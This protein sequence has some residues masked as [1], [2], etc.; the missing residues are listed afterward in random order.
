MGLTGLPQRQSELLPAPIAVDRLEDSQGHAYGPATTVFTDKQ[1]SAKQTL[2]QR[3][4]IV[5]YQYADCFNFSRIL[6][7]DTLVFDSHFGE[8]PEA[9]LCKRVQL[10]PS[11][12]E[13]I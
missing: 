3:Q 6:R 2:L 5:V 10:H 8:C 12:Y 7:H 11:I 9:C 1:D 13:R 4:S